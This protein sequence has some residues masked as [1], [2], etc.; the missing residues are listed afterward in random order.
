[1]EYH[2]PF[3]IKIVAHEGSGAVKESKLEDALIEEDACT[4]SLADEYY[5]AK[6]IVEGMERLLLAM[7]CAGLDLN[8]SRFATALEAAVEGA[9]ND[10]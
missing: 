7:A 5:K 10:H 8:D 2:L 3:G 4:Q 6:G 9:A 1:M